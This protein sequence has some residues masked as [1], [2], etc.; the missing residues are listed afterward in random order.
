MD[1]DDEMKQNCSKMLEW[2]EWVEV[3]LLADKK[4]R[5][6]KW[7]KKKVDKEENSAPVHI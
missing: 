2:M 7:I 3:G 4:K 1:D 5:R 6:R